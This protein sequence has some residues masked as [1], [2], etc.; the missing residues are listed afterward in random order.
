MEKIFSIILITSVL[1]LGCFNDE[2]K[3]DIKKT[4]LIIENKF[5]KIVNLMKDREFQKRIDQ[6]GIP[7]GVFIFSEEKNMNIYYNVQ[8]LVNINQ[9]EVENMIT[10]MYNVANIG[11]TAC[12][13]LNNKALTYLKL[14]EYSS[15]EDF[16]LP[17]T[18]LILKNSIIFDKILNKKIQADGDT[19]IEPPLLTLNGNNFIELQQGEIY[20]EKGAIATDNIDGDLSN[21]IVIDNTELNIN[22]IGTYEITYNVIDEAGNNAIELKRVINVIKEISKIDLDEDFEAG[23]FDKYS[24]ILT[25]GEGLDSNNYIEERTPFIQAKTTYEGNNAL[26]FSEGALYKS[27]TTLEINI[28]IED[29]KILSFYYKTDLLEGIDNEFNFF[30]DDVKKESWVGLDSIWQQYS[31]LLTEGKHLL[32]WELSDKNG[33]YCPG[34]KKYD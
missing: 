3:K 27:T 13:V 19:D 28:D 30:V 18:D 33:M 17:A 12:F 29:T 16:N 1:F 15:A 34:N 7:N 32:K 5:M 22:E 24:W 26:Q 21:K 10:D 23:N 20:E 6:E 25:K 31:I 11:K 2:E 4:N 8:Y 9:E 14:I